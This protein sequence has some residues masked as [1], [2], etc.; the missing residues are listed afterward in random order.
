M[1]IDWHCFALIVLEDE[2]ANTP[3]ILSYRGPGDRIACGTFRLPGDRKRS[4]DSDPMETLIR[5]VRRQTGL[6]L[7][8]KDKVALY[9]NT[10]TLVKRPRKTRYKKK[11]TS[12]ERY[13]I[14]RVTVAEY[15]DR[16]GFELPA[17]EEPRWNSPEAIVQS[18]DYYRPN[19]A[20]VRTFREA[21]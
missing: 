12:S 3:Q 20:V 4:S 5:S 13:Y 11:F 19:Q 17:G 21:S 16:S 8:R 15:I 2:A 14:V 9:A 18:A 1:H 7:T 10:D 6:D